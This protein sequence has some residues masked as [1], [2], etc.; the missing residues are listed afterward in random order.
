MRTA[1]G[2]AKMGGPPRFASPWPRAERV[3][4]SRFDQWQS[5]IKRVQSLQ[6]G[7]D[8]HVKS[9]EVGHWISRN[10]EGHLAATA[11]ED[12]RFPRPQIDLL[13]VNLEPEFGQ[14]AAA[15]VVIA[16]ARAARNEQHVPTLVG[17]IPDRLYQTFEIV[18]TAFLR[19]EA[20]SLG[21]EQGCD[22]RRVGIADLARVRLHFGRNELISGRKMNHAW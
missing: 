19:H 8:G 13:K 4:Q 3:I 5:R 9:H 15:E 7:P 16:H 18:P 14:R 10:D 2:K 1:I 21:F 12:E 6:R 11:G 17:L 20:R 22:E